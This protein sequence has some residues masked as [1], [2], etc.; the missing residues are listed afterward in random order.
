DHRGR[1][2]P[3]PTSP[4]PHPRSP[5]TLGETNHRAAPAH[6][7]PHPPR[8]SQPPAE[9]HSPSQRTQ[10]LTTRTRPPTRLQEPPARPP[11]RRRQERHCHVHQSQ[12]RLNDKLKQAAPLRSLPPPAS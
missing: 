12:D 2:H 10:T 7:R 1:P 11:P 6:P 8:V 4:P 3:A 9:N 5:T